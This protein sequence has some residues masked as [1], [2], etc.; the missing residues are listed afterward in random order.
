MFEQFLPQDKRLTAK[1]T[2]YVISTALPNL[3]ALRS[4]LEFENDGIRKKDDR[5]IGLARMISTGTVSKR[6]PDA[7]K[8][9]IRPSRIP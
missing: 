9:S 1:K 6:F 5:R 7:F 3:K 4:C 2:I 8:F